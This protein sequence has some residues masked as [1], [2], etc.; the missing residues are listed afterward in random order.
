MDST[1]FSPTSAQLPPVESQWPDCA[2]VH[3]YTPSY[4]IYCNYYLNIP[5]DFK[6][7][8]LLPDTRPAALLYCKDP[9]VGTWKLI[10]EL[11]RDT[12]L[13]KWRD[14]GICWDQ[15][16]DQVNE[17]NEGHGLIGFHQE[18]FVSINGPELSAER[19]DRLGRALFW[20]DM[21]Y[22]DI[23]N[24]NTYYFEQLPDPQNY[25]RDSICNAGQRYGLRL[26]RLPLELLQNIQSCCNDDWFWK[27][28]KYV[29]L[30]TCLS[31]TPRTEM[32]STSLASVTYWTRGIASPFL[33][34]TRDT[35]GH[36][37]I[38]IDGNGF[39]KIERLFTYP[40]VCLYKQLSKRFIILEARNAVNINAYFKDGM[41]W[42]GLKN[43]D[44]V[45]TVWDIP[46]P[47]GRVLSGMLT[48][49]RN[50]DNALYIRGDRTMMSWRIPGNILE[51]VT[52]DDAGGLVV[53]TDGHG[54]TIE[55]LKKPAPLRQ[56]V[57]RNSYGGS[58]YLPLAPNDRILWIQVRQYGNDSFPDVGIL[59][60][61]ELSGIIH[62]G[63]A[64]HGSFMTVA[65]SEFPRA[66]FHNPGDAVCRKR[67]A[68]IYPESAPSLDHEVLGLGN[69]GPPVPD[70]S[71]FYGVSDLVWSWAP[72]QGIATVHVFTAPDDN[73]FLGMHITY[74]NGG[75]RFVGDA[76]RHKHIDSSVVQPKEMRVENPTRLYIKTKT[77]PWFN[78]RV[79]LSDGC[80]EKL[81]KSK[82]WKVYDLTGDLSIWELH[83][84]CESG[85]YPYKG[86]L[87]VLQAGSWRGT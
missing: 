29:D 84:W 56:A 39:C 7:E 44:L 28:V 9:H 52:L 87:E 45:S 82:S 60:K 67:V 70:V 75:Q 41:C 35:S 38:T 19:M 23:P 40:E 14:E 54:F 85:G 86:E 18:C 5:H 32:L 73:R 31:M 22:L 72:L 2:L 78:H 51:T 16:W 81:D 20:T 4:C 63:R 58:S 55:V 53:D 11:T 74:K 61:T 25:R 36:V 79:R 26:D 57:S 13:S 71:R 34:T 50:E 42:L 83:V 69:I 17:V 46:T 59:V 30:A 48:N 33:L 64:A 62:L 49:I 21:E 12:D 77:H 68:A 6:E 3:F 37:R 10:W 47:P 24:R 1:A 27:L 8:N 66:I 65:F 80:V 76:S 43:S 15:H